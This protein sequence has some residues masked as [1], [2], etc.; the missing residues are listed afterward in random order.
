VAEVEA[1]GIPGFTES[2]TLVA[3]SFPFVGDSKSEAVLP[4]EADGLLVNGDVPAGG[5][6]AL[7]VLAG[8]LKNRGNLPQWIIL[9]EN[10]RILPQVIHMKRRY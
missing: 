1:V 6:A 10:C 9:L 2:I 7:R 8:L 3:D 5:P 4:L